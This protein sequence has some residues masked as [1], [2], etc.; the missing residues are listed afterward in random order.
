MKYLF[1]A[2][3]AFTLLAYGCKKSKNT[4]PNKK[5]V[6]TSICGRYAGQTLV[7]SQYNT[8]VYDTAYLDTM[9]VTNSGDTMFTSVTSRLLLQSHYDS[10]NSYEWHTGL[11]EEEET[12]NY[13]PLG[14]SVNERLITDGSASYVHFSGKKI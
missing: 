11:Y 8:I 9:K 12:L 2:L 10:S 6:D 3:V 4:N 13:F 5:T 14:D 1:I 7:Y